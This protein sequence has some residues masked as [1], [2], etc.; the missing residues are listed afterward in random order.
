MTCQNILVP[1]DLSDESSWQEP[2]SAAV[3]Y[4]GL[5]G[6]KVHVITVIPDDMMRMT[7]VAQ[8]IPEDFEDKIRNDA[9]E[10]LAAVV[11]K[12]VPEGPDVQQIVHLGKI[13][14]EILETARDNDVDLIVMAAHKPKLGDFLT[15]SVTDQVIHHAPCSVWIVR[16]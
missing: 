2:L 1:V 12:C 5:T 6:A 14:H 7:V 15:G 13:H 8:V 10:R 11:K 9:K 3:E 16:Q 4:A